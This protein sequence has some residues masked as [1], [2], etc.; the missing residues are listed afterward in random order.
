MNGNKLIQALSTFNKEE[1][2]SYRRYLLMNTSEESDNYRIFVFLQKRK[3]KLI[4]IA[5]LDEIRKK[6]FSNLSTKSILNILSRLYI[7]LEDW[8]VYYSISNDQM[9]SD[10][11]LV[12]ELNRRGLYNLADQKTKQLQKQISKTS[13]I[14]IKKSRIQSQLYYYQYYSDNPIKR[15]TEDDMFPTLYYSTKQYHQEKEI[16]LKTELYNRQNVYNTDYLYLFGPD[17]KSQLYDSLSLLS[18]TVKNYDLNSFQQI[19]AE[20]LSGKFQKG[21]DTHTVITFYLQNLISRFYNITNGVKAA[22]IYELYSYAIESGVLLSK[23]KLTVVRFNN[24]INS[25]AQT[26]TIVETNS[27]IN[28]WISLVDTANPKALKDLSE[29][30]NHYFHKNYPEISNVILFHNYPDLEQKLMALGLILI[31]L[32]EDKNIDYDIAINYCTNMKRTIT[33][34]KKRIGPTLL[35]SYFNFIKILELLNKTRKSVLDVNINDYHPIL[36]KSWVIQK[37]K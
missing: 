21:S 36:F 7:W 6:H 12:K 1:W 35:K 13:E 14:S 3:K 31:S 37:I 25:I 24:L 26:N 2:I 27:F 23:G 16:L 8:L 20:L 32:Y 30:K 5:E 28:R 34:N 19:K 4:D 22:D 17:K 33:R 29:A 10:L 9:E 18:D 15:N 11:L